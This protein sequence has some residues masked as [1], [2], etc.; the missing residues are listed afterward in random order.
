MARRDE[1]FDVGPA[2]LTPGEL[3]LRAAHVGGEYILALAG[4]LDLATA[5]E[6]EAKVSQLCSDGAKAVVLDL[7]GLT[8]MDSTGLRALL[9]A[10]E[11][12]ERHGCGLSMTRGQQPVERLIEVSGL[13][14]LLPIRELS[15]PNGRPRLT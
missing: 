15:P 14:G 12:C 7:R 13:T 6:L 9:A 1:G 11:L 8:F 4:E 3:L 5:P 2:A 10:Q